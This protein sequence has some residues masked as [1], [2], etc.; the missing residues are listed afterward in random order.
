MPLIH[1][2]TSLGIDFLGHQA[3]LHAVAGRGDVFVVITWSV[4][5]YLKQDG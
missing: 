2:P 1:L 3:R 5:R 4:R